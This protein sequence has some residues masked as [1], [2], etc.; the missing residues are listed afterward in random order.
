MGVVLN[1][2]VLIFP[3]V[4]LN[5]ECIFVLVSQITKRKKL[6]SKEIVLLAQ[7]YTPCY[8]ETSS[9]RAEPRADESGTR[10]IPRPAATLNPTTKGQPLTQHTLKLA[11]S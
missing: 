10:Y 3:A 4:F 7:C 1:P 2:I 11:E 8:P 9:V 6:R 5:D